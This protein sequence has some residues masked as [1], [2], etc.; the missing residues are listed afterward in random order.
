MMKDTRSDNTE[1]NYN[2]EERIFLSISPQS[3]QRKQRYLMY[4]IE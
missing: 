3:G 1:A 4:F 2:I